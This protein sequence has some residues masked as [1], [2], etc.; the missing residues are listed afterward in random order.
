ML[1]NMPNSMTPRVGP[2]GRKQRLTGCGGPSQ[3]LQSRQPASGSR[4]PMRMHPFTPIADDEFGRGLFLATPFADD[5][6][7]AALSRGGLERTGR[8]YG[9]GKLLGRHVVI[10]TGSSRNKPRSQEP[11]GDL[12]DGAVLARFS[13]R[14]NL[15]CIAH[16]HGVQHAFV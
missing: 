2:E 1:R 7:V 16:F 5:L 9:A 14:L 11:V 12:H 6:V 13:V 15:H 10:R 4:T 8:G 3:T